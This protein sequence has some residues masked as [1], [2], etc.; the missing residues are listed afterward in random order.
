[1]HP[2]LLLLTGSV[3]T[4]RSPEARECPSA[5]AGSDMPSESLRLLTPSSG[6]VDLGSIPDANEVSAEF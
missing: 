2:E 5:L 1:M 4:P 3:S 6:L